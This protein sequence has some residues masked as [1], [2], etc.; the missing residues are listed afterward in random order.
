ME[1]TATREALASL[2]DESPTATLLCERDGRIIAANRAAERLTGYAAHELTGRACGELSDGVRLD[3][4]VRAA[5]AGAS[6]R[7]ETALLHRDAHLVR[8]ECDV[9]PARIAGNIAGALVQA[10]AVEA[11]LVDALTGL[12][13][14]ALLIDRVEQTLMTARRYRYAFAL[15]C[16]DLDRFRTINERIGH[17]GGDEVLRIVAQ[18]L[19]DTLRGS[20]TVSRVGGGE[21]IVLAPMI[22]GADDAI[23]LAQKI[24]FAM[25]APV[26]VEGRSFQLQMRLGIA[27]FP[28]DGESGDDLM[29]AAV[30]ALAEAKRSDRAVWCSARSLAT[31]R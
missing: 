1:F 6:D 24:V 31:E 27:V 4:A 23:D 2:Y 29:A 5:L 20:D 30:R 12:P 17:L 26:T 7:F 9:F 28:Q 25:Q 15:I 14:R 18:R 19:R 21:F 13:N 11:A 8:I 10:R 22:D 3:W 16:A